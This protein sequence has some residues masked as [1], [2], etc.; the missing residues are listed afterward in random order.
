M[1]R[2]CAPPTFPTMNK[3]LPYLIAAVAVVIMLATRPLDDSK[4][5]LTKADSASSPAPAATAGTHTASTPQPP[6]PATTH[7]ILNEALPKPFA[8][9]LAGT[10]VDG[11]FSVTADG[12][13]QPTLATRD[14]FDYFLSTFGERSLDEIQ[15]EI[16]Q[17]AETTLP[18]EAAAQANDLLDR[19]IAYKRASADFLSQPAPAMLAGETAQLQQLFDEMVQLRRMHFS[20]AESEALFG[21]EEAYGR[22]AL[23]QLEVQNDSALSETEKQYRLQQIHQQAP[24]IIRGPR[25]RATGHVEVA[26]EVER[27]RETGATSAEVYQYRAQVLGEDVAQHLAELD[28]QHAAWQERYALYAQQRDQLRTTGMSQEDQAAALAQL[29]EQYFDGPERERARVQDMSHGSP[30]PSL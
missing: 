4:S 27:M 20:A 24:E 11:Y 12:Q 16:R 2:Y 14:L 19:Y 22:Y 7:Q 8:P 17:H 25:Q 23:A 9:S 28:R 18:A 10:E 15:A 13:L 30:A 26:Q 21:P 3:A 5:P 1:V 29:R 6:A